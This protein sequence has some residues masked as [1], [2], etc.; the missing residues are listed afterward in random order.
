M[1]HI[2][3]DIAFEKIW[4]F[5][6]CCAVIWFSNNWWFQ[7]SKKFQNQRT[8]SS[9]FLRKKLNQR[10]TGSSC[11][12]TSKNWQFAWKN[13]FLHERVVFFIFKKIENQ[14]SIPKLAL[15]KFSPPLGK[16]VY[17]QVDNWWVFVADANNRTTLKVTSQRGAE[18]LQDIYVTFLD[19]TE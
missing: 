2:P 7:F 8:V 18:N 6:Q 4:H 17:L 16:Q 3:H 1:L 10:T 14:G 19:S 5:Y 9:G 13:Q 12:E 11:S 15:W